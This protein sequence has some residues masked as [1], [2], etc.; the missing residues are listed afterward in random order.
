[1]NTFNKSGDE[2][3]HIIIQQGQGSDFP[4]LGELIEM[5]VSPRN[6]TKRSANQITSSGKVW[7]RPEHIQ[8][9]SIK[10]EDPLEK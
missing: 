3:I 1:M 7:G 4:T 9:I 8:E 6:G 2:E 5:I 10:P